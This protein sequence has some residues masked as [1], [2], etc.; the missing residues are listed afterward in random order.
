MRA[1]KEAE[2]DL[3][4]HTGFQDAHRQIGRFL[5]EVHMRKRIPSALG[6]LTPMELESQWLTQRAAAQVII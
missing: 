3:T 2:V 4:E 5:E 1:I 6:Y